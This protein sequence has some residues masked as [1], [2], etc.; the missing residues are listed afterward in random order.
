MNKTAEKT[1]NSVDG[2]IL[3]QIPEP[4]SGVAKRK[5]NP[6]VFAVLGVVALAAIYKGYG[7][8]KF[9]QTHID[10][11]NAYV[12]GDLVNISP[13]VS[14][15]LAELKVSDGDFV[16][17]GDLIARLDTD[18]AATVLEQAKANLKA[19]E[20]Q[21]PQAEAELQFTKLS[22]Q[23]AIQ[24]SQ[25]AITTQRSKTQGSRME[26]RLSEDTVRNQVLQAE[27][28]VDQAKDQ[29]EQAR[30]GVE[31]A[32]AGLNNAS[33]AVQTAQR[34]AEAAQ[35]SVLS[36]KA[37]A[38]RAQKDR[39]RYEALFQNEAISQQQLDTATATATAASANLDAAQRRAEAA[40]SEV[41]QAKS[42]VT[43]SQS[44]LSSANS[45]LQSAQMQVQVAKAGLGLARANG[46]NVG[47]QGENVKTNEG[48]VSQADASLASATAGLQQIA[49][50]EKQIATAK[51]QLE[52]AKAAVEHASIDVKDAS[53]FAPCDGYV[54][55]HMANVGAAIS[56]GQTIVTITHGTDVWVMA[57]F[58]E[59]QLDKVREGQSVEIEVDAYPGRKFSGKV[60]SILQA[61]GSATTLLPPDNST[62]NF[63]KVVQRVPVKISIEPSATNAD[64]SG[65]KLRQGMS[66]VAVVDTASLSKE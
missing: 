46:T 50:R 47:I 19:A 41:E 8:I 48:Q 60:S 53:L 15:T 3:D 20:S 1:E 61:T 24:S 36:A 28:Q 6:V 25:A 44:R 11:D 29:V 21:I 49:L 17:K 35:A 7:A 65:A 59:T 57:N 26:V 16:H 27:G 40:T 54:V 64:P 63:T 2:R 4:G 66:V 58:K 42:A 22:T 23:A 37:D 14:G 34:N 52:Q 51:A 38:D 10:T 12:T 39:H 13:T 55:K 56:P 62:G 30:A 5:R 45:Q 18:S 9:G 31:V 33:L 43:E 32:K